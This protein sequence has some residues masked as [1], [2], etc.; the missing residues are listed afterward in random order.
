VPNV[1]DT[2]HNVLLHP[3]VRELGTK[4]RELE[5]ANMA[6]FVTPFTPNKGNQEEGELK[7]KGVLIVNKGLAQPL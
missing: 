7:D 3:R 1:Q 4:Y 6:K 5:R 2:S